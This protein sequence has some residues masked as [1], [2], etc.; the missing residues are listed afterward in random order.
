MSLLTKVS[1]FL[2][3]LTV[4]ACTVTPILE[5]GSHEHTPH[6]GVITPFNAKQVQVGFA[7]LKLHDDKGDLELWLTKDIAGTKPF[8]LPLNSSIKVLFSNLGQKKVLLSVRNTTTN[9][10]E[11]GNGNIRQN[12]TNY[13]IFPGKTGSDASF[14]MGSDFATKAIISFEAD[15]IL[16][17][18]PPFELYP[19]TH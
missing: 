8:D 10:D 14:L 12:K 5:T 19:H 4:T 3:L 17:T 1:T 18:T 15:G 7:E 16:Y 11:E 6:E 9:E 13:F 2:A